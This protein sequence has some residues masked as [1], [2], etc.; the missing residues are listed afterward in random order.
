MQPLTSRG[1][2]FCRALPIVACLGAAAI[3]VATVGRASAQQ[4]APPMSGFGRCRTITNDA[5]RLR[6]YETDSSKPAADIVSHALGPAAGSWRLVRTHNP[7]SG[8]DAISI[9][10][11]ADVAK[12]DTDVAGLML[13]CGEAGVEVVVVLVRLLPLRAH[14]EVM[15]SVAGKDTRFVATIMPPGAGILLPKEA[16]ALAVGPWT[17]SGELS[18]DVEVQDSNEPVS[19][20]G[21]IPLTGLGGALPSLLSNCSSQ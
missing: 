12:S 20:R 15:T 8:W 2:P 7:D 3:G 17:A 13:R 6:C 21:V 5:A 9:V 4:L 10:Q 18:M 19:I 1:R 16:S 11:T 14:P